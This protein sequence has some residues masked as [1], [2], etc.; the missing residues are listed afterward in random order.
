MLGC[1]EDFIEVYWYTEGNEE[2]ASYA[3]ADPVGRLEWWWRGKL[4]PKGRATRR[5]ENGIIC[6]DRWEHRGVD[7]IGREERVHVGFCCSM[8]IFWGVEF[9][10]VKDGLHLV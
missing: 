7:C 4:R 5:K 1:R 9:G 6:R 8:D 2:K 3:R 10:E